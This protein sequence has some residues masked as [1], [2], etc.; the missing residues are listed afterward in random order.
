M[1]GIIGPRPAG[2]A[3]GTDLALSKSAAACDMGRIVPGDVAN[4]TNS[5]EFETW[6]IDNIN[7][8]TAPYFGVFHDERSTNG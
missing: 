8:S 4:A 5:Y 1:R 2:P 3:S 6:S 7:Q